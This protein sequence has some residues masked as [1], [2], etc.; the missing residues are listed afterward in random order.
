MRDAFMKDSEPWSTSIDAADYAVSEAEESVMP[1]SARVLRENPVQASHQFSVVAVQLIEA[2]CRVREGDCET[3]KAHIAHAVALL[4]GQPTSVPSATRALRIAE[5]PVARG[6]LAGWQARR[7]IAYVDAN[8]AAKIRIEDL[9]AFL[10]LSASHFCRVFKSTF[11]VS[12]RDYVARRRIEVAQGLMLTTDDT[13]SAIALSCGM[14]DQSHF[15]RLFH[16]IV[17]ETPNSWRRSRR[18]AIEDS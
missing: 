3:A 9:A 17:G 5:R 13:L 8:L 6:G 7:L 10:G 1:A 4:H 14:S 16:R 18:S 2:A 15:T 11:G 12:P